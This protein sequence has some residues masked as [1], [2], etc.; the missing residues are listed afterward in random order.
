MHVAPRWLPIAL[1]L[2]TACAPEM[3]KT[4]THAESDSLGKI[5]QLT[6]N[7]D[8]ASG[9]HFSPDMKWILFQATPRGQQLDQIYVA[10]VR[11]DDAGISSIGLPIQI[12]REDSR[13]ADAAFSPDGQSIIFSSTA[14]SARPNDPAPASA[15][16]MEIFRADD[17]QRSIAGAVPG[18][19]AA[20]NEV[21]LTANR[22][23]DAECS[24]TPDGQSI[25]FASNRTG[26]LELY[27]MKPDGS[28]VW[29]LTI[30]PGA[31]GGAKLSP[32]GKQLI[33]QSDRLSDGHWQIY[34]AE[35]TSVQGGRPVLIQE[36]PLTHD[37]NLNW[38]ATWH[39][40]GQ[41]LIYA[42]GEKGKGR[43]DLWIMRA[44]GTL[45]T[46][47]TFSETLNQSPSISPD[48]KYLL[49]ASRRNGESLQLFVARFKLPMGS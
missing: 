27:A 38:S 8:R 2:L 44:D 18:R 48:G 33:Y 4:P 31:D 1:L 17:W 21:A 47:I 39:P 24:F 35:M 13:N 29:R 23:Y 43:S 46:Q 11:Y 32:N 10:Q 34:S 12:S 25:L 37:S 40:D 9:A 15:G 5:I 42:S 49:W 26:D 36:K 30:I 28:R 7:F 41:H 22:S 3:N 16:S 20:M 6:S 45:K 19:S 14:G